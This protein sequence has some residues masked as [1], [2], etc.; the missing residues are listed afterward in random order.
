MQ[1]VALSRL[2]GPSVGFFRDQP[3]LSPAPNSQGIA[4]GF[5]L[6]PTAENPEKLLF[7]GIYW[8]CSHGNWKWLMRS[9]APIGARDPETHI[10]LVEHGVY[11]KLIGCVTLTLPRYEG[12]RN[13]ELY[14]DCEGPGESMSH[15]IPKDV[16]FDEEWDLCLNRLDR[17]RKA[18]LVHTSRIHVAMPCVAMGT[19]V[20]YTGKIDGRTSIIPAIGIAIGEPCLPDI[21]KW[22]DSYIEYLAQ[23]AGIGASMDVPVKPNVMEGA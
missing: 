2:V 13:G 9:P 22:R 7:A 16:K 14:V 4:A 15:S 3:H 23:Y 8:L 1:A 19:P 6:G 18:T 5:M 17:Y 20:R 12:P 21:R 11:S 10:R